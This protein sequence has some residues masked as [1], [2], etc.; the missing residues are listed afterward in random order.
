M[1]RLY[2][3]ADKKDAQSLTDFLVKNGQVLLPMVDLMEQMHLCVEEFLDCVCQASLEAVLELSAAN[4]AGSRHQ[5]KAGGEIIRHGS[6]QGTVSLSRHKL[7]V[8]KPRL[9]RKEGGPGAEVPIP[10]YEAM[11]RDAEFQEQLFSMVM[12]GVST[13]DYEQV[14]PELAQRC[15]VSKS[16]VSREFIAASSEALRRL[17][18]RRFDD[19]DLLVIYI[20]GVRL[21]EYHVLGA[22]GVDSEG[23]KHV[24]GLRQGATE[25][26]VVVK[27][28]LMDLV[29]RGVNPERRRLFVIDGSKA[30][31]TAIDGVFGG[32][33]AV[34]RCRNHK[35]A[36]VVGHLP[37]D[38]GAQVKVVMKAA[39]RL[40]AA[41]GMA[42][43]RQQAEW[44]ARE[45]PSAAASL[46]EG[47]EETFTINRLGLSAPLQRCLSTTNLIES[48][49]SGTRHRTRRVT[50]WQDGAMAL[51]W[52]AAACLVTEQNFRRLIGYRDLWMLKSRLADEDSDAVEEVAVA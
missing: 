48:T 45:Y 42:K 25:N 20:D 47:L 43:L 8:R 46:V 52:S 21:Q 7:H 4:V 37:K 1:E 9:R 6:Q 49:I 15:G 11:Q 22:L 26:A 2:Q 14:V 30:L 51:R 16:S 3:V 28:L 19:V 5:G 33:H 23:Q 24:L 40:E 36:N 32:E 39:Y 50:R 44:L 41:K 27:E 31:R 34:Q 13:R 38:L 12:H 18:E 35:V 29:E 10:A 17:S